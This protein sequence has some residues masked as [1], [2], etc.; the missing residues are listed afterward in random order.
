[1]PERLSAPEILAMKGQGKR[2]ACLTAYDSSS[3]L[4]ADA[5][6]P[7][8]ILV[9]DSVGNVCLGYSTTLPVTLEDILHHTKACARVVKRSLLISDLPFGSYQE[10]P[11][12]A[13]RSAVAL[14]KAGA[15]GVKLEG[16]YL[17][18]IRAIHKAGIPVMGHVG[19]TPQSVNAFGGFRVQ[20]RANPEQ[21]LEMAEQID[22]C[23]V[24]AMVLEL[25]PAELG[26]TITER[27]KTAT[28]GIGAGPHCDGEIQVFHDVLGLT[29]HNLKHAKK[30][31][32][33]YALFVDAAR[34]YVAEVKL[35][36]FPGPEQSF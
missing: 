7:D 34:Q 25:I 20:G 35:K 15:A 18:E 26:K 33:G 17:D 29:P 9:G 30:Y 24:F 4:I 13:V 8:L 32:D 23:G 1:M 6:G 11:S 19:F 21:I 3:A 10:G 14:M 27:V 28:I 36:E 31:V 12:Q 5:A 16:P 2:I 22:A